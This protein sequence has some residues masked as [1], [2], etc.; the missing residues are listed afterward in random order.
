MSWEA[1]AA[2]AP[3]V[4]GLLGAD[5]QRDTNIANA[6]QARMQME[7]QERMSG[8]AHQREVADLKAAGLNPMLSVMRSGASTPS[9]AM[10]VFQNPALAGMQVASS[11]YQNRKSMYETDKLEQEAQVETQRIWYIRM[12]TVLG[13]RMTQKV[14]REIDLLGEQIGLKEQEI[15]KTKELV[16][17]AVV[18]RKQIEATTQNIKVNTLLHQ[19]AVQG[20]KNMNE[21]DQTWWG[22]YVKPYLPDFLKGS[23]SAAG[24]SRALGR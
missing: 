2:A 17:N 24:V 16:A 18:Q 4:G 5:A 21:A 8:T 3:I 6:E 9:G 12:Q 13:E 19:L 20:A 15:L 11:A 22:R 7:F 23:S 10:A 14:V 1:I